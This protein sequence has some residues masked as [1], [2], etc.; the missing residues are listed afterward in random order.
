MREGVEIACD[1]RRGE[2]NVL[3]PFHLYLVVT[4]LCEYPFLNCFTHVWLHT[5]LTRF[6]ERNEVRLGGYPPELPRA[7]ES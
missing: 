2:E 5:V 1:T 6:F 3:W 7:S 4:K